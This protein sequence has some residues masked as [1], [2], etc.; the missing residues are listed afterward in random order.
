MSEK[1]TVVTADRFKQGFTYPDF[2]AQINVNQDRFEQYDGTAKDALTDEDSAFF[3]MAVEKGCKVMV[4]GEDWCPDVYRGMPVVARIAEVSG[5]EM[6]VF[7]RD[8]NLDIADEFLNNGEFRS[9]PTVVFY[10]ADQEFL[11][12][13]TERPALAHKEMAEITKA[14]EAE[15]AGQDEEAVREARRERV[16]ARFPAWQ[17]DTVREMREL[18]GRKLGI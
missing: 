8:L 5:M 17:K 15:M 4:L 11:G 2:I 13:W 12:Q 3:K 10:T 18:L 14:I 9:I 6:R 16:N 1:T 7:P